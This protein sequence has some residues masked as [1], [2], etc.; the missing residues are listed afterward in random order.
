LDPF[1][2]LIL[3]FLF[4]PLI[5]RFLKAGK[6]QQPPEERPP[7][8]RPR[9]QRMPQQ[10]PPQRG[11][12]RHEPVGASRTAADDAAADMLPDDLWEILTGERRPPRLPLPQEVPDTYEDTYSVE[13][14]PEETETLEEMASRESPAPGE[15]ISQRPEETTGVLPPDPYVRPLP[16]REMPRVVSL[17][18]LEID[19]VERHDQFH[20]RLDTLRPPA[21]VRRRPSNAYRFTGEEDLRRA[22]I[23]AEVLGTPKGLE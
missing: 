20:R 19:D 5:E 18:D 23:M 10:H 8:Q 15:W 17:E 11:E 9:Q 4:A 21:R 12:G 13:D 14:Y 3:V 16:R 6:A 1:I 2:L 7:E 22:I